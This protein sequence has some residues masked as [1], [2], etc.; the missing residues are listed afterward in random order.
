[1]NNVFLYPYNIR[2]KSA[3]EIVKGLG[4]KAIRTVE[5]KFK[6]S[7]DKVIINWGGETQNIKE[8][9]NGVKAVLNPPS[10]INVCANKI[11]FFSAFA[12]NVPN[13]PR[14]PEWTTSV[15]Q[16]RE[17][18]QISPVM[19]RANVRGRG[20]IGI[21]FSD[22]KDE[23][24]K[25]GFDNLCNLF[26]KYIPKAKEFRVHVFDGEV[27]DVA[28][29]KLRQ[30]DLDGKP[31]DKELVN[32]RVRSYDNGFIFARENVVVPEDVTHQAL[33]AFNVLKDTSG[34]TFGAFDIIYNNK[35]G[36]ATV[37]ECNTAPGLEG[38]TV[39]NYINAFNNYLRK[40]G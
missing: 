2:S 22:S 20:G 40:V 23:I 13:P 32:W 37:L 34:L 14:I 15:A 17:W 5:S 12:A 21:Y 38:Q 19:G 26:T 6:P 33:L 10:S 30:T 16:A 7:K 35:R 29:K 8:Y 9:S 18:A 28:E 1:M 27:I 11:N 31:V 3:R 36:E 25:D 4:I 24:E 39:N